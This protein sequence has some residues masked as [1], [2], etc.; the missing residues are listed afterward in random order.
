MESF[1]QAT[2]LTL[3]K[4]K[5]TP[6]VMRWEE[7]IAFG[8]GIKAHSYWIRDSKDLVNIVWLNSDGIRDI[9]LDTLSSESMFNFVPLKSIRTIEVRHKENIAK[10]LLKVEGS[11]VIHVI[12]TGTSGDIWWVAENDESQLRLESFLTTVFESYSKTVR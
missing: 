6:L 12:I 9:T 2:K 3:A 4:Y 7:A 1:E 11:Y 5:G 10:Q 8:E